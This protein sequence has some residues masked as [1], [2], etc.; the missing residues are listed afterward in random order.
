[1]RERKSFVFMREAS[2]EADLDEPISVHGQLPAWLRLP[3][4]E[5]VDLSRAALD[6]A[7]REMGEHNAALHQ[8]KRQTAL[9]LHPNVSLKRSAT[10]T[11]NPEEGSSREEWTIS[12]PPG[13]RFAF[14]T[15]CPWCGGHSGQTYLNEQQAN[16]TPAEFLHPRCA[17][18][19]QV[20]ERCFE[21]EEGPKPAGNEPC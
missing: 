1:M 5:C 20:W 15:F 9:Y 14:D 13:T 21:T 16:G 7:A 2:W 8:G 18:R 6:R 12:A 4:G 19:Q 17:E 3:D 10:C 11:Y